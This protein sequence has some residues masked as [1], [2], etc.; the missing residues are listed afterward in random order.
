MLHPQS[1]RISFLLK[2]EYYSFI[3]IDHISFIHSSISGHLG[4]P[5]GI[6]EWC[7]CKYVWALL[8]VLL[9]TYQQWPLQYFWDCQSDN[10]LLSSLVLYICLP[11]FSMSSVLIRF[12]WSRSQLLTMMNKK[13]LIS[14]FFILWGTSLALYVN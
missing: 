14:T 7:C 10:F 8:S 3:C 13:R 12:L 6:C 2:T 5:F 4:F 11:Y 9:C 1:S